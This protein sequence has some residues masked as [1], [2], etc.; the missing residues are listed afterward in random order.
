MK[1]SIVTTLYQSELYIAEFHSRAT[2]VA[3]TFAAED[4]E[5][6][7]V[8]DG[9]PDDSLSKA[10]GIAK[11]DP[12]VVVV[13]LS[14]NFGHHKAI[15]TGLAQASGS[16]IFLIDSDLEEAPEWLIPFGEQ[17]AHQEC[18]V[19]FGRQARRKGKWFERISG[20]MFYGLYSS[21]LKIEL[22]RNVTTA[23]LMNRRYVNALTAHKE[24][25]VFLLGL[26]HA[27]GFSQT[28]YTVEKQSVSKTT[29]SL[30]S[31]LSITVNSITSF[32]NA[33]LIW[34]FYS[35]V[36]ISFFAMIY[37]TYLVINW[38]FLSNPMSGWTSVIASIWLLGGMIISF[39]GV[40]GIYLS[41][42]FS[43]TKARPYTIIRAIHGLQRSEDGD[44]S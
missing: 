27:T 15:M 26:W 17:M 19:V 33:P 21:L 40:I 30:R 41:K 32:S 28:P 34:I 13:D 22:P 9:S 42:I 39:I 29:Y 24:S 14:R 10:I 7:F 3:Q 37:I 25:E 5:I 6:I 36:I 43:E 8:N 44:G 2:E 18:D 31:K 1:L 23:R 4:Y 35:G 12:H 16:I 20:D 11:I 38:S